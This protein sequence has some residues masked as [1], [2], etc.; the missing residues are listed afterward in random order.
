MT[1]DAPDAATRRQEILDDSER[2]NQ[3]GDA[4]G[5]RVSAVFHELSNA[6]RIG[7]ESDRPKMFGRRG[8]LGHRIRKRVMNRLNR[9][10]R[11][12]RVQEARWIRRRP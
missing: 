4:I 11:R 1:H 10:G 5:D 8:P 6:F 2:A 12:L 3:K 7:I 9:R